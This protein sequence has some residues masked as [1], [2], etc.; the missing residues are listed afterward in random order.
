MMDQQGIATGVMSVTSPG[1]H[2]DSDAAARDLAH[3]VN[4]YCA[5]VVK[6]HFSVKFS[7]L[8]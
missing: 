5:E 4:E 8:N 2:L 1:V 7:V 6:D 3:A